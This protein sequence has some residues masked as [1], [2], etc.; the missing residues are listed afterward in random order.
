MSNRACIQRTTF[1]D[2]P[3]GEKTFGYRIYDDHYLVYAD[4][5]EESI[6]QLSELET[7]SLAFEEQSDNTSQVRCST[8]SLRTRRESLSTAFGSITSKSRTVI[9]V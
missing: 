4:T 3:T 7:I 1:I 9:A 6:F 2:H 8:I 5:H